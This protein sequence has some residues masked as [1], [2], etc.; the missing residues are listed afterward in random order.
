[1]LRRWWDSCAV[2]V[3]ASGEW[4][5][6]NSGSEQLFPIRHSLFA[7]LTRKFARAPRCRHD[8]LAHQ[9]VEAC[10][11]HQDLERGGGGA[12][13]RGHVLA[14]RRGVELRAVQEFARS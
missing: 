3:N 5:T 13:R 2:L 10:L 1:M 12:A 14:Q 8:G 4:R 7:I 6:A 11:T 9:P